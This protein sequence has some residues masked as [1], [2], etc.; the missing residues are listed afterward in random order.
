MWERRLKADEKAIA[1]I[2]ILCTAIFPI[3]LAFL[4][5][6]IIQTVNTKLLIDPPSLYFET[7]VPGKRFS[8]N[9]TVANVTDLKGYEFKLSFNT[10]MLDVVTL[11]FLPEANL[12][13]GNCCVDDAAGVLWMN[14]TYDGAS[15][16]TTNAVALATIT[17]KMMARGTSPLHLYDTKLLN[18]SGAPIVH[19]TADG[20]V[21]ILRHDIAVVYVAPSTYE[22]YIGRVVNVTVTAKNNGDVAENFTVKAYHNDTVTGTS[23]VTNLAPGENTTLLFNWDTSDAVAGRSYII[24]A[25]ATTVLYEADTT[26]NELVDG[27][28]KVK[29]IGDVTNDN[30]VDINDLVA[31]DAAYGTH[32]GE[33]HWNPQADING[34]SEVDKDDGILIIQNYHSTPP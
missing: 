13:V 4:S 14:A 3:A 33:P 20:V 5:L 7:L 9:V 25:N 11:A 19:G 6:N 30:V 21:L 23:N 28:V 32:E 1:V 10:Q 12:P 34:N 2:A 31:W 15:I 22:T 26:N 16:T 24:K 8:I 27:T 29:I 18:S 17:F